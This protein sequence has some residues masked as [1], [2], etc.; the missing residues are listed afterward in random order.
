MRH[1]L[2]R[3]LRRAEIGQVQRRIGI[4]YPHQRH[5]R[6]IQSLG[7]HL[8]AQQNLHLPLAKRRQ[9][10]I[11]AAMRL[12]RIGIHPQHARLRKPRPHLRF[13]PLRAQSAKMNPREIDIPDTAPA[14]AC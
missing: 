7:D 8:C 9:C 2:K 10:P 11:V 14:S 12:H 13:Q 1:Q 4:D 3:P 6:K 5:V